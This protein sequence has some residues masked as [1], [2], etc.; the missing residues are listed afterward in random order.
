M[1]HTALFTQLKTTFPTLKVEKDF[2]MAPLTTLKIGGPAD[3]YIE[4]KT[5]AELV[6]VLKYLN[7]KGVRSEATSSS[8]GSNPQ[9]LI[10]D[11]LPITMLGNGSNILISDTGIRGIVIRNLSKEIK[12]L[13]DAPTI[14]K[15]PIS[16]AKRTEN[17]PQKYLDFASLDYDESTE[18]RVQVSLDAGVPLPLCY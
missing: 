13:G 12:I 8:A 6:E 10:Q 4:I 1:D 14:A 15:T 9:K 17:E 3:I 18:P 5:N 7:E 11:D 2:V 16:L